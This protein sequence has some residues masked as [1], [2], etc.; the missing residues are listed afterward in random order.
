MAVFDLKKIENWK[1]LLLVKQFV[2]FNIVG[3]SNTLIDIG[4]FLATTHFLSFF[5]THFVLANIL[6]FACAT[7][8]SFIMNRH[9]T[10]RHKNKDIHH[11]FMK[12]FVVSSIGVIISSSILFFFVS[13][14]DWPS[15]ISKLITIPIVVLWGFFAHKY[16]TFAKQLEKTS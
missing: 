5:K 15:S 10:F 7:S 8:S 16:W 3:V 12:F 13:Q 2:K 4:I 11:Q 6:A 14:F 9:W 1:H